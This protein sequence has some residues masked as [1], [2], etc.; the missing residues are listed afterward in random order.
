[1]ARSAVYITTKVTAG[2]GKPGDCVANPEIALASVNQ[3]LANLG[4]DYIDMILL[5]RPCEQ[6]GQKCSIAP[7][8]SNCTGPSTSGSDPTA[9]NNALWQGLIKA[10]QMGL[11]KSIGVSNYFPGQLAAL[12]GE[13]PALNQ[14][15]MSIQGLSLIHI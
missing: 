12:Q 3:S 5:H 13:K 6:S 4:V 10:K 7:K 11:V 8:L 9:A 15:E 2:C 1:M 14:C